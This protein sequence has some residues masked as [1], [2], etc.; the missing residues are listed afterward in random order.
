VITNRKADRELLLALT[1][2]LRVSQGRLHRDPCGDWNVV[3][4]RGHALA[5]G[6]TVFVYIKLKTSRRWV[7]TKR[8]LAFM[9][10]TQDGDDEGIL[11]FDGMP[12]ADQAAMLRKVIGLRK[13]TP[14][15]DEQRCTLA[16][17]FDLVRSKPAVS[18]GS[19]D[20]PEV[21]ATRPASQP[22]TAPARAAT[23]D[24]L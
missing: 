4:T 10:V 18:D 19:I 5:D 6:T 9:T 1:E 21:A 15:T 22:Q 7:K 24:G 14:L 11:K 3:G 20:L 12:T 23:G 16:S 13:V 17:R 2:S 8:T